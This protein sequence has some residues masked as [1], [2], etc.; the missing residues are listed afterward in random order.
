MPFD[1]NS[2]ENTR[3]LQAAG[4]KAFPSVNVRGPEMP[5]GLTSMTPLK[6]VPTAV[7]EQMGAAN[8]TMGGGLKMPRTKYGKTG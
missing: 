5:P 7:G 8:P 4:F 1:P 6:K 2:S 3:N